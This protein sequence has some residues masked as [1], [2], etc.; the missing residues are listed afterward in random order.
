MVP[1]FTYLKKRGGGGI[2]K[3]R[4]VVKHTKWKINLLPLALQSAHFMFSGYFDISLIVGAAIMST[5]FYL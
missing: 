4:S 3:T 5:K 2:L 1:K